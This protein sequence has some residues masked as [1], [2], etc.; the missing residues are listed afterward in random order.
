MAALLVSQVL[1][2]NQSFPVDREAAPM[3]LSLPAACRPAITTHF[4]APR[5]RAK[6]DHGGWML[7]YLH[8]TIDECT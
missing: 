8:V 3:S 5:R 6:P 1:S 2:I 7:L 4:V